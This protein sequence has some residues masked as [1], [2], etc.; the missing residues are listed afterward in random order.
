[1]GVGR[2]GDHP[3]GECWRLPRVRAWGPQGSH[4]GPGDPCGMQML[5]GTYSEL[6]PVLTVSPAGVATH[7]PVRWTVPPT[8]KGSCGGR[9]C[10]LSGFGFL[11][12]Q[13]VRRGRLCLN[14]TAWPLPASPGR[15]DPRRLAARGVTS[16]PRGCPCP[17]SLRTRAVG[18]AETPGSPRHGSS[19]GPPA[20]RITE[21]DPRPREAGPVPPGRHSHTGPPLRWL[22]AP[23]RRA[24]CPGW[25]AWTTS[26]RGCGPS[27]WETPAVSPQ[28]L[29]GLTRMYPLKTLCDHRAQ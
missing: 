23:P 28:C 27:S 13:P 22:S 6:G 26:F 19:T 17:A 10:A 16:G 29:S 9:R 3:G 11:E 20:R 24:Q 7:D 5:P 25:E 4:R 21:G 2:A 1:M 18:V 14:L 15:P 8:H 12:P